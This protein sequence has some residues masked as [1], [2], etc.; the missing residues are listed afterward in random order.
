MKRSAQTY[1]PTQIDEDALALLDALAA[2][3]RDTYVSSPHLAEKTGLEPGRINDAM[4]ILVE[5]GLAESLQH[6]GMAT[7]GFAEAMITA[8]GRYEHQRAK[9]ARKVA[10]SASSSE[11]EAGAAVAASAIRPPSPGP[12]ETSPGST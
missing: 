12:T 7:Y 3:P 8:R 5:A 4:S 10:I 1:M 6:L 11:T 2:E 9:D